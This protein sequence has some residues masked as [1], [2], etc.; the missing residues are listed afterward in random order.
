MAIAM[1]AISVGCE[2]AADSKPADDKKMDSAAAAPADGTQ[3]VS[4]KLPNMTWAG[5]AT[6]VRGALESLGASDIKCDTDSKSCTFAA[7]KDMDV[8]AKLKEV[9]TAENKMADWEM[10]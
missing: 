4:L 8:K 3:T 6:E 5:C 1:L 2:N 10:Q 9:A 7:P